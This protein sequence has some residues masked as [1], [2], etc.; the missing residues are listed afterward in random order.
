MINFGLALVWRCLCRSNPLFRSLPLRQR[1]NNAGFSGAPLRQRPCF[2]HFVR[3]DERCRNFD[4]SPYRSRNATTTF[5]RWDQGLR[6]FACI[7]PVFCSFMQHFLN[8][9][10]DYITAINTTFLQFTSTSYFL[11]QVTTSFLT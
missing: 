3:L 1:Y 4:P 11:L 5:V 6:T 9:C 2:P 8:T 10:Y 7:L